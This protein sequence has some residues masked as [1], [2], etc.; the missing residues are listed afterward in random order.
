MLAGL[1]ALHFGALGRW[2]MVDT[3]GYYTLPPEIA[4]ALPYAR[5]RAERRISSL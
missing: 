2:A 4:R 5:A 1:L 3:W